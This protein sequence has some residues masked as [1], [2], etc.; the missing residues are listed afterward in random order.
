MANFLRNLCHFLH[1]SCTVQHVPISSAQGL[2]FP[3]GTL[4]YD[5][6]KQSRV[7]QGHQEAALQSHLEHQITRWAAESRSQ[8]ICG[9]GAV[10]IALT[11][12][13]NF[14]LSK[15]MICGHSLSRNSAK[16]DNPARFTHSVH[17][18][19]EVASPTLP[20]TLQSAMSFPPPI[21]C[22]PLC[23]LPCPGAQREKGAVSAAPALSPRSRTRTLARVRPPVTSSE[24]SGGHS[25]CKPR[26][27]VWLLVQGSAGD[28]HRALCKWSV[29]LEQAGCPPG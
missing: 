23:R 3:W 9:M 11:S 14:A 4:F 26:P 22:S 6:V 7:H 5:S 17:R 28:A 13:L 21:L 16:E 10:E 25:E 12:E 24:L 19:S 15:P 29:G 20:P 2:L 1:S 18:S 8:S 27:A